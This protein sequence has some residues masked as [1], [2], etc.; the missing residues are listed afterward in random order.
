MSCPMCNKRHPYRIDQALAIL[1]GTPRRLEQLS[2]GVTAKRAAA[3]PG[4]DKWSLKEIVCHLADCEIVYGFRY[5]KILAEPDAV[6]VPFD[7][8]AWAENLHYRE[9]PLKEALDGL[10]ALRRRHIA[11]LKVIPRRA[12]GKAGNHPHY[13]ALTLR[14]IVIHLVDHDRNHVAQV[15]RLVHGP[16]K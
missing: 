9:Q 13:G 1:A 6:L 7:Q 16:S 15:E 11:L 14:Q 4:P 5:R 8:N 12:W 10:S 2:R 3:R